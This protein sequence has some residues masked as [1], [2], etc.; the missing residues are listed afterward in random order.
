MVSFSVTVDHLLDA[1]EC[2][3]PVTDDLL[4]L[5]C[6]ASLSRLRVT[7][8]Q[9]VS[10]S[11]RQPVEL[12]IILALVTAEDKV[13]P[14]S[15]S[16]THSHPEP[17]PRLSPPLVD[18]QRLCEQV[19]KI[20]QQI[21]L[22]LIQPVF[23]DVFHP[24]FTRFYGLRN[25]IAEY[26]LRATLL[27]WMARTLT[28]VT[29]PTHSLP[30]VVRSLLLWWV[31]H[32]DPHSSDTDP[33]AW[34]AVA[35]L[36]R[37]L[38]RHRQPG[39]GDLQVYQLAKSWLRAT[40]SLGDLHRQGSPDEQR[41]QNQTLLCVAILESV[42]AGRMNPHLAALEWIQILQKG[43]PSGPALTNLALY[44]VLCPVALQ[45]MVDT[46]TVGYS[47]S[48]HGFSTILQ[49]LRVSSRL[50]H[51]L[52]HVISAQHV[53]NL[54]THWYSWIRGV[55]DNPLDLVTMKS[56]LCLWTESDLP[57][58]VDISDCHLM[59]LVEEIYRCLLGASFR[60]ASLLLGALVWIVKQADEP[61][62]STVTASKE[63]KLHQSICH[64]LFRFIS[65]LCTRPHPALTTN[66]RAQTLVFALALWTMLMDSRRRHA[67]RA[68]SPNQMSDHLPSMWPIVYPEYRFLLRC[69]SQLYYTILNSFPDHSLAIPAW[70]TLD[71][72]RYPLRSTTEDDLVSV[73]PLLLW[74][75]ALAHVVLFIPP[76]LLCQY[77]VEFGQW[78]DLCLS[79]PLTKLGS[80]HV[81]PVSAAYPIIE[82]KQRQ[83][84][85]WA[86]DM[87][88]QRLKEMIP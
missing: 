20:L 24:V 81:S 5:Q 67:S 71:V 17:P 6:K 73:C 28:T 3:H 88:H 27:T 10:T 16:T 25:H 53:K 80:S 38:Y 1:I 44:S 26:P 18:H 7:F 15:D 65:Y 13:L 62:R 19:V 30:V 64:S 22:R 34:P 75:Q 41:L 58:P 72:S 61:R 87:L 46:F 63:S 14:K 21:Q 31:D 70:D 23:P 33:V 82:W 43:M 76:D 29:T 8:P 32:V 36:C 66:Q 83:Y 60:F 11:L 52:Y 85:L 86:F 57:D 59:H 69:F 45:P 84:P 39:W 35:D 78:R 40:D 55:L 68:P 49:R 74:N 12:L 9:L 77:A 2:G 48:P 47:A 51:V 79:I 50:A 56:S 37:D 42:T 4:V 54:T